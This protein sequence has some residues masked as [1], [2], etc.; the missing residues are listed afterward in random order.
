[1]AILNRY[2]DVIPEDAV[3]IMRPSILGN[4]FVIGRDGNRETVVKKH[5]IYASERAKRDKSF[6]DRR[7]R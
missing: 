3:W 4:P 1:M 5:L 2:R 6:K 7:I